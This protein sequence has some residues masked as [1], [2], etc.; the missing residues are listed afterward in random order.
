MDLFKRP[1]PFQLVGWTEIKGMLLAREKCLCSRW[2]DGSVSPASLSSLL[3]LPFPH[4]AVEGDCSS[5]VKETDN[6]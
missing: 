1:S 3:H 4:S 5:L 2:D 6:F